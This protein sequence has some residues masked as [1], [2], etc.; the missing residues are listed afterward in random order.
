MIWTIIS[1]VLVFFISIWLGEKR[2]L[3]LEQITLR[4][5]LFAGIIGLALFLVLRFLHSLGFF[6]QEMAAAF[7]SSMYASTA[8]FFGGAAYSQFLMKKSYGRLEY[9]NNAFISNL[10]PNIIAL[11]III[12]GIARTSLFNEVPITPIRATSGLSLICTGFYII[13]LR[14][15]P[16]FREKGFIILD[17]KIEWKNL[18][19]YQWYE[20]QVIELE[21]NYENEIRFHRTI[22]KMED[23]KEVEKLLSAK[24]R[25]KLE[26]Q[27]QS[28]R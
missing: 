12:L 19:A 11:T 15:T 26:K 6:P 1:S 18:I 27:E 25:A 22:I 13:T 20:D 24:M 21:F 14:T 17:R 2:L 28:E 10:L 7:M 23:E 3:K 5:F 16:E 8:G 9:V 4:R